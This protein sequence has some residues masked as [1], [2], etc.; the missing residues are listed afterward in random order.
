MP[1]E[2]HGRRPESGGGV[3]R[4]RY[5]DVKT[6]GRRSKQKTRLQR[7]GHT[8]LGGPRLVGRG[9]AVVGRERSGVPPIQGRV[10]GL[11]VARVG[12]TV[13]GGHGSVLVYIHPQFIPESGSHN[14]S[15]QVSLTW[16]Q[17]RWCGGRAPPPHSRWTPIESGEALRGF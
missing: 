16:T 12:L 15:R 13:L 5:T 9:G 11:A 7:Q 17:T 1:A 3:Q 8:L 10:A 2:A 6:P 14:H 4:C